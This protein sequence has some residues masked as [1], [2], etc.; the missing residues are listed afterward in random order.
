MIALARAQARELG[1]L[2]GGSLPRGF[3][4]GAGCGWAMGQW[5]RVIERTDPPGHSW[6]AWTACYGAS[7]W[8]QRSS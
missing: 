5:L 6:R 1:A 4:T 3:F 7:W 8:P 2:Y